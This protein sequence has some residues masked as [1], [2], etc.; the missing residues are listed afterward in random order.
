MVLTM[1]A[2]RRNS[3]SSGRPST[4]MRTV[5]VKLPCAT[6]AMAR[7]TSVVG[8][9][10]SSTSVL[11]ETSISPHA[12]FDWANLVRSRV[13][14]SLPTTCPH[15]LQL[16]RH[17]LIGG[18]DLVERV[19]DLAFQARPVT[20]EPHGEVAVAHRLQAVQQR[21]NLRLGL[22]SLSVLPIDRAVRFRQRHRAG[23][24]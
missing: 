2:E 15:P 20:G 14:P 3:P 18:D 1:L 5:C 11:T 7:V 6:A 8:R 23:L 21:A 19:G 4:S 24:L 17:L 13:L 10:R 16:Q 9:S 22:L 12:P